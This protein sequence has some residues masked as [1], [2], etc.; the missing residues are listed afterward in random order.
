MGRTGASKTAAL[1][2]AQRSTS[3]GEQMAT[4]HDTQTRHPALVKLDA[5]R[6]A[7]RSRFAE[8]TKQD[9]VL[10]AAASKAGDVYHKLAGK[11]HD[12]P[13]T[14]KAVEAERDMQRLIGRME[15]AGVAL[16]RERTKLAHLEDPAEE[17]RRLQAPTARPSTGGGSRNPR[18]RNMT[19]TTT[20]PVKELVEEVL[21]KANKPLSVTVIAERL[22]DVRR[23]TINTQL[24]LHSSADGDGLFAR[25]DKGVYGLAG[26][27]YTAAEKAAA[28]PAKPVAAKRA[29]AAAKK[30]ARSGSTNGKAPKRTTASSSKKT[31]TPIDKKSQASGTSRGG[32]GK[33][34]TAAS[35][36]ASTA[37]R[38][39]TKRGSAPT[40][41]AR[42][43][44]TTTAKR[45]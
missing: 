14:P 43:K 20:K 5:E 19:K 34:T 11:K 32:T 36:K 28:A 4:T 12:K 18:E 9:S 10:V 24:A 39:S 29:P 45:K 25:I 8:L 22:P 38:G 15:S 37:K 27:K 44:K 41:V 31:V 33:R 16:A 42:T 7:A 35:A 3:R 1:I 13:L 40:R 6:V 26:T 30:S 23:G 2:G 21:R 17:Q